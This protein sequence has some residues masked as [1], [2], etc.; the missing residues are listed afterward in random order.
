MYAAPRCG[1]VNKMTENMTS[2]V[3]G[4][5]CQS[6][7]VASSFIRGQKADFSVPLCGTLIKST[8]QPRQHHFQLYPALCPLGRSTRILD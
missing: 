8:A 1:A 3:V 2:G 6:S 7:Q 5:V 4:I